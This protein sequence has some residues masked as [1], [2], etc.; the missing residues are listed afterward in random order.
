MHTLL[1][2]GRMAA[3]AVVLPLLAS[4]VDA[5]ALGPDDAVFHH[6]PNHTPNGGSDGP[7]PEDVP[8]RAAFVEGLDHEVRGDGGGAYLDGQDASVILN[9]SDNFILSVKDSDA[10]ELCFG[11]PDGA[12]DPFGGT[13]CHRGY[14]STSDA[15]DPDGEA[16]DGGFSAM[17]PGEERTF[18]SQVTWVMSGY[19]WFL[20]YGRDCDG[21]D[22][23]ANRVT[24][25]AGDIDAD[26]VVDH[27]SLAGT[28]AI[29]C[30]APVR[31]RPGVTEVARFA[32]GLRL[33]IDRL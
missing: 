14:V 16:L 4:C 28:E 15:R 10:R 7:R 24:V 30:Q 27:W 1:R 21:A 25:N 33:E 8:L 22:V 13:G 5:P 12:G 17:Q 11:F 6:K 26:G 9:V 3:L 23:D 32:M 29:L 18:R 19:N 20:R 31:G 2:C